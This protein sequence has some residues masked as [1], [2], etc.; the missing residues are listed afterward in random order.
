[1]LLGSMAIAF[2]YLLVHAREPLRLNL[3][4]PW[5]DA[6]VLSSINYVKSDGFLATSFV[7]ILD[8]GPLTA[9]SYRYIHYPPLAE[10]IYGSLGRYLGIS[11]I[12]TFR[13]FALMFSAMAMWLLFSYVRRLYTDRIA[14][15]ST[16]LF[17]TSLIWMMYAD[18][19]H[20]A[21]VMQCMAFLSLWG[22]VRAIE[23]RQRRHYAAAMFGAFACF[24]TSY[25]Y[26][27][28]LPAAVIATV[29]LKAGS[30]LARGR[31]HFVLLCALG[32][33]LGIVVKCATVIGAVGWHEF[34]ADLHLQFLERAAAAQDRKFTSMIPTMLRRIT[35]VF[36]PFAWITAGV[37]VVKALRAPNLRAAFKDTAVWMLL[38]A[39]VF[40]YL[41]AQLAA[42]QMLASQVLLPFYAIGSALVLDK[43]LEGSL[44][45]RRFAIAWLVAAPLWSFGIMFTHPRSVLAREDVAN[46]NAYLAANDHNDFLLSNLMSDGHIQAS[47]ERHSWGAPDAKD[48]STAALDF[49]A[50]FERTGTD[51]LHEVVFSD[52]D[53]RFIDKALWPLAAARGLWSVTGWPHLFRRKASSVIAEY[54][55]RVLA[56]LDAVHAT[57]VLE[58]GNYAVYRIDRSS[59]LALLA[60]RALNISHLEFGALVS[61]RNELLGWSAPMLLAP[62]DV[63]VSSIERFERCPLPRSA[64]GN[65]C[66]T[67]LTKLGVEVKHAET[68][69]LGQLMLRIDQVCDLKLTFRFASTTYARFTLGGFTAAMAPGRVATFVVPA[70]SVRRGGNLLEVENLIP[71]DFGTAIYVATLDVAPLCGAP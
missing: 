16:A 14:L 41:F 25:D 65:A 61:E 42:S 70:A 53:S 52:P 17:S 3:G 28:F 20:Q 68:A 8:V 59:I 30:P 47:F 60:E 15:V 50:I 62:E 35:M 54:D 46:T 10:I 12:G 2:V 49:L 69:Q 32:C 22:L 51:Q 11:D 24:F 57:K 31:R 19:I 5:S 13:L 23:T 48:T 36:T 71:R 43:L 1:M 21:P 4:D 37:H 26:S 44:L 34:L 39:L 29:A 40:L 18:S 27:V 66:K 63:P 9:D 6:N 67:V 55:R 33:V 64:P 56:N 58:L 45:L 7:D 38:A